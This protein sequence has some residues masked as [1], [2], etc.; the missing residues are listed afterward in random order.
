MSTTNTPSSS[1]L[2]SS[3]PAYSSSSSVQTD[4]QAKRP[5][6]KS[7]IRQLEETRQVGVSSLESL[8]VQGEQLTTIENLNNEHSAVLSQSES[9]IRKLS[10]GGR[11]AEK[12]RRKP[13]NYKPPTKKGQA[14]STTEIIQEHKSKDKQDKKQVSSQ[15]SLFKYDGIV[16]DKTTGHAEGLTEEQLAMVEEEDRDLD[17][18]SDLLS[19]MK[20]MSMAANT[21]LKAQSVKIDRINDQVD[22]NNY[23][24]KKASINLGK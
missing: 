5:D 7:M 23:R 4:A 21:E 2:S 22:N 16:Y 24:L 9:S 17:T 19:S 6:T 12:F 1:S 3:S 11:I 18:M 20:A 8:H 10:L 13:A 15:E 14:K